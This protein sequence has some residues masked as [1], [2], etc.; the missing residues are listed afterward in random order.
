MP[1]QSKKPENREASGEKPENISPERFN[2]IT[3][4]ARMWAEDHM[5]AYHSEL[6]QNRTDDSPVQI[7]PGYQAPREAVDFGLLMFNS[8]LDGLG[9]DPLTADE[10]KLFVTTFR[11]YCRLGYPIQEN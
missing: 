10:T 9:K 4:R 6:V 8:Y 3:R 7:L 2:L 1:E 5:G 11:D